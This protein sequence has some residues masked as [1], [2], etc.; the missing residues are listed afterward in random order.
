MRLRTLSWLGLWLVCL[1][2]PSAWAANTKPVAS[3]TGPTSVPEATH[4]VTLDGSGSTD[5]DGDTLTYAWRQT[6]GPTVALSSPTAAKP[7]FP[8]P[9]VSS[10]V[11]LTFELVVNDGT[12]NSDPDLFTVT[13]TNV[14]LSLIAH[15]GEDQTVAVGDTVTLQGSASNAGTDTVT[16][17]WSELEP[18]PKAPIELT[19]A[20]TA[21]PTFKA[22]EVKDGPRRTLTFVL[23]V[24]AGGRL[25]A[26]DTV[27]VTVTRPNRHPVG[28]APA[29]LEEKEDTPVVLDAS[30]SSDPDGDTLT[31]QWTQTGGPLV[32]LKDAK[33]AKLS[34]TTPKVFTKTLLNFTLVVKDTADAESAPVPVTVTVLHVN[35]P[36]VAHP[37]KLPS[38]LN[39][40]SI[41]LD[42]STSTDPDGDTLTYKWQQVLGSQVTLPSDTSPTVTFE[43]PKTA[44]A[45]QIQFKLTVTDPSGASN[46]DVVDVLVLAD[47]EN[48]PA[49]CASTRGG[50]G[51]GV[52]LA[53]LAFA[54]WPRRRRLLAS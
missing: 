22:P 40:I 46:S 54:L 41:T 20:G 33:T 52:L 37:R 44:F 10:N 13:V 19:G 24:S 53:G 48:E 34:F 38:E 51:A 1:A 16:Y 36:P 29:N 5:A 39:P 28:K 35:K 8:A 15:A 3:I 49:G 2:G 47:A 31:Y 27:K 9:A 14:D 7:T 18:D 11:E 17:S 26:P 42:G 23:V 32:A 45:V 12:V 30:E 43:V 6:V 50:T 4:P 25:S 21:T